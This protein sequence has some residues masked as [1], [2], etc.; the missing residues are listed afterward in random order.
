MIKNELKAKLKAGEPV[1]G[2]FASI[3]SPTTIE[4][5]ALAG[6]DY[7]VVDSEHNPIEPSD[8]VNMFR[9][10]EA[11]GVP[12]MARVGENR[13]QV[14][15]KFMDAGCLGIMMPM[16]NSAA[17]AKNVVDSV[18]YPPEGNRGLAGVRA[19][20]FG[21]RE[22]LGDYVARANT[23][24]LVMAQIE[25]NE[26]IA[27]ADE[28]LAVDGVDIV[29]LGPSDLSVALGVPGQ[30]KHQSVLDVIEDL[31][32]KIVAAGKYSGTIART[33]EDYAYWRDRGVKLFLTGSNMLLASATKGY[34]DGIKAIED[35]R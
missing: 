28:I 21:M 23:E 27:N 6:V 4:I 31:T 11:V 19:N 16:V 8:A 10:A 12:A 24:T 35:A 20:D 5:S 3:E 18:K 34:V 15:A 7:V 14:M 17:D 9:A 1:V 29:F 2:V 22:P 33:P 32:K 26:G 30:A 25:T 13:Q